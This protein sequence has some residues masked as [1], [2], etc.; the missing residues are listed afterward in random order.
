MNETIE[1]PHC[2]KG[3]D[4]ECYACPFCGRINRPGKTWNKNYFRIPGAII[5][6]IGLALCLLS[7]II[8]IS[9]A[10]VGIIILLISFTCFRENEPPEDP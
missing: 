1:C 2:K 9:I 4:K 7:P 5:T 8:G 6:V 3:I 10:I